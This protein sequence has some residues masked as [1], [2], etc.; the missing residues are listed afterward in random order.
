MLGLLGSIIR[1]GQQAFDQ[2]LARNVLRHDLQGSNN[3]GTSEFGLQLFR[4]CGSHN[5]HFVEVVL[6]NGEKRVRA[7]DSRNII[8]AKQ[9]IC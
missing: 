8:R 6:S 5:R 7:K 2:C 4:N 3:M 1:K 9:S